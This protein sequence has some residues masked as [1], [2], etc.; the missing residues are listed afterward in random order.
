MTTL[1]LTNAPV[2]RAAMLIRKPPAEVFEAIVNPD[3]TTKFWFTKSS[4]RLEAG[5]A[6]TW[7]WEMYNA[8][9]VVRALKVERDKRIVLEWPYGGVPTTIDWIF[10]PYDN[11]AATYLRITNS[12]FRG[13]ADKIVKDA[14]ESTG[15]FTWVLAGLKSFLEHGVELGL[16]RDAFPKGLTDH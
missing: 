3:I 5:T 11:N 14:L 6:V 4:G 2:A 8:S 10:T 7:T 16:I 12:G 9:V 13:V 15:G 1:Q